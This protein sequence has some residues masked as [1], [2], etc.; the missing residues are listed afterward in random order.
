M[1]DYR[2]DEPRARRAFERAAPTY[3]AAARLEQ[4][5][6]ARM[7]ERLELVRVAP[8][9]V[10]DAGAGPAPHAEGLLRRYP[11]ALHVAVDWSPRMLRE[12][13]ARGGW[14]ARLLGSRG[15]A[16][17]CA[18]MRRVPL[19]ASACGLVWSNMALHC[20]GDPRPAFAEF[21]R[22]LVPGGLL[23]FSTLGPDTLK[24]LRNAGEAAG[25]P[26]LVHRFHDMHDLGD[27]L[28]ESG[29]A[30]PVMDMEIVT[31]TYASAAALVADLRATGQTSS[32]TGRRRTLSG[33]RRWSALRDKLESAARDGRISFTA[34][35][36]YGHAWKAA[37]RRPP[38]A[39]TIVR[40]QRAPPS[41]G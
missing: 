38:D 15:A 19:A 4:E 27:M 29:F 18:D 6:G 32:A 10:L 14:I 20:I 23:M 26:G 2:I 25:M 22:V 33:K 16:A 11:G 41:G 8:R 39:R 5:I 17:V 36:V 3:R 37:T 31:L 34:E 35:V 13:T 12:R 28:G 7:L 24:E 40:L 9:V 21:A 30:S 1:D